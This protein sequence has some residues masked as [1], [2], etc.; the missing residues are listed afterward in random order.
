MNLSALVTEIQNLDESLTKRAVSAVNMALTAR[1]W[2]IGAYIVE[3]EQ[4]G[5][6]RAEYGVKLIPELAKRLKKGGINGLGSPNLKRCRQFYLTYP[7]IGAT[8][9]HQF[10]HLL[11]GDSLQKGATLSHLFLKDLESAQTHTIRIGQSATDESSTPRIPQAPAHDVLANLSFSHIVELLKLDDDPLKRAFY[12]IEAIKG[13]WSV[14]DLKRQIGSLLFERTGLSRDKDKL[15]EIAHSGTANLV[16]R[17]IIRDPYIFEFLGLRA[18]ETV[19]ESELESALLD[20]LQSFLL[21]LGRGFCFEE[22]QKK[23][24][25]GEEYFFIDLVFYHRILKCHVLIDLK[26]EPFSHANAGQLN[27]YL[28]WYKEHEAQPGDQ[29]PVGL[30]LCTDRKASLAKYALGGMDENLFV[31]QYQVQLP[32]PEELEAFLRNELAEQPAETT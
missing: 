20:H 14:R 8:L 13:R 22:R 19:E 1:N 17:D 10:P 12:E 5:E 3:F 31:S 24:L 18:R 26:V 25:I 32:S 2:L 23:I 16:P 9:P 11:S 30:L 15:L 7:E 4:Q 21:E 28:N 29:A 27:T 6:D